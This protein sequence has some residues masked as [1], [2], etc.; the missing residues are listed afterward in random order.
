LSVKTG[1]SDTNASSNWVE[2]GIQVSV[3]A[4]Y[5]SGST[6]GYNW[7]ATVSYNRSWGE[8]T[9]RSHTELEETTRTFRMDI[10]PRTAVALYQKCHTLSTW[11]HEGYRAGQV[12]WTKYGLDSYFY[13]QYP[14][15][16][17]L[18]SILSW[19]PPGAEVLTPW[20]RAE[21]GRGSLQTAAR[22]AAGRRQRQGPVDA[23]MEP[24]RPRA[25]GGWQRTGE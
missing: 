8:E 6:P 18:D 24:L 14:P 19:V 13:C 1:Y 3:E 2:N 7:K 23:L 22:A 10:P 21:P 5:S 15:P 4:G 17:D 9:S 20:G 11:R 12:A 25:R 16:E